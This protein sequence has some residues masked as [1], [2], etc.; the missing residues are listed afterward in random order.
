MI[1][2]SI[3]DRLISQAH[4]LIRIRWFVSVGLLIFISIGNHYSLANLSYTSLYLSAGLLLVVNSI[5][6]SHLYYLGKRRLDDSDKGAT[7]NIN[8]QIIFDYIILSLIL[9]FSGG[10]ENPCIIFFVFHMII[11][12]IVLPPKNAYILAGL[13]NFLLV[14]ITTT[15]HLGIIKHY[16][17]NHYITELIINE[18]YYLYGSLGIFIITSFLAVYFAVTLSGKLRLTKMLLNQS[19]QILLEKDKIKNEFIQRLSHDI[20]GSLSAIASLL[21]VVEKQILGPISPENADF[22]GKAMNR[23]QKLKMFLNDL[24]MLTKMRLDNRFETTKINLKDL[25]N[26]VLSRVIPEAE[27]KSIALSSNISDESL[28]I[29]GVA[30][31]I[32]EAIFNVVQNAI[33]YTPTGGKVHIDV[34]NDKEYA[35]IDVADTGYGIPEKD[36]PFIF[37]E[38]FR[39]Q[40]VFNIEGT[41]IGLSLVKAII[42]RHNGKIA[43]NSSPNQGTTFTLWLNLL[44]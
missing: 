12:S 41:G 23:T 39:A 21:G 43:V 38:F 25:V 42:D 15:E 7:Y 29:S 18:P 1:R 5:Y 28:C 13:A 10:I 22:I 33:K 4:W 36:L 40:N 6:F 17:I 32:E 3:S 35:I 16:S 9:H 11:G 30:V 14:F 24:L 44:K 8:F 27:D 2:F 20:K 31:S 37:D 19:N 26:N 34:K